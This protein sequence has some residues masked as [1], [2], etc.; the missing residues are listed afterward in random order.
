LKKK[1]PLTPFV[2]GGKDNSLYYKLLIHFQFS[3][4]V[5][6]SGFGGFGGMDAADSYAQNKISYWSLVIRQWEEKRRKVIS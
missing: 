5:E 4:F 2:K 6:N 3:I 1:I